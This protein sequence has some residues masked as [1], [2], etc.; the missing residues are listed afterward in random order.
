MIQKA[1]FDDEA[2]KWES[3]YSAA[4][5]ERWGLFQGSVRKRTQGRMERCLS[6]LPE[7]KNTRVV[8]LACGPGFYGRRI[9][10]AGG[11]WTGLDISEPMLRVCGENTGSSRMVRADVL[12]LPYR[13]SSCDVMLCVGVLSYLKQGEIQ[14]L[15]TQARRV[16]RPGGLF[17][18]QTIRF[19]PFTWARCRLP[20]SI[21]RPLRIPGPLYPRS[22]RAISRLL[23]ECGFSVERSVPYKKF[24]ICPA[25]TIHLAKRAR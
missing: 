25:G 9:I 8:E 4:S 22:P 12:A 13:D 16:L 20:R 5:G 21:P 24:F 23:G 17:L 6:L 7:L 3:L 15:F 11:K 19:D 10:A 18:C 1:L 2:R 14:D